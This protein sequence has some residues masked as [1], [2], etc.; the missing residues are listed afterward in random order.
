MKIKQ[1]QRP[2]LS[3]YMQPEEEA[4]RYIELDAPEATRYVELDDPAEATPPAERE[5]MRPDASSFSVIKKMQ[6]AIL[7]FGSALSS[8]PIMMGA[9]G[10]EERTRASGEK[11]YL[12]ATDPFGNFLVSQYVNNANVVGNQFIN[13]DMPEPLRSRTATPDVNLKSVINT[14]SRVGSPG[15][16]RKVDGIWQTRTNNAL[17][18]IY[19][20]A[21]GLM[22]FAHDMGVAITGF[23]LND[24]DSFKKLIPDSYTDLGADVGERAQQITQYI[25]AL[26]ALYMKFETAV[27]DNPQYKELINQDK[28]LADH[29]K[30]QVEMLSKDEAS[31]YDQNKDAIIPGAN[32]GGKP[33]RLMDVANMTAFKKF[34]QSA[35]IDV[36]KPEVVNKQL[37]LVK[38][39]IETGGAGF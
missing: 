6:E 25:Y 12:G 1:A 8:H 21:A 7:N 15:A 5:T 29:S 9:S 13:I 10:T 36:S 31:L 26:T 30:Q 39:L 2:D 19:A 28:P 22:H 17:K 14:I 35:N 38:N 32:I 16:E 4:S 24:L 27:L 18:Q 34:L 23:T 37:A 20:V 11:E 33:V 3:Q